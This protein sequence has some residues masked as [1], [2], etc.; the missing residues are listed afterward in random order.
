M[1]ILLTRSA[2]LPPR[3]LSK[4]KNC[5]KVLSSKMNQAES[6]RRRRR[7]IAPFTFKLMAVPFDPHLGEGMG[8]HVPD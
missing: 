2:R 6:R 5:L 8:Y 1:G 7:G 4:R 3:V